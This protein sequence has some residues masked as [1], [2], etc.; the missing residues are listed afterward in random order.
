MVKRGSKVLR[1][2][3]KIDKEIQSIKKAE[4]K[5][6]VEEKKIEKEEEKIEKAI[7][8]L[9]RLTFKRQHFLELIRGTA[10]AF[11][12]VGLGLNLLNLKN[13]AT[14]LPWYN[15][16][17]ILIFILTISS[18]LIYKNEKDYVKTEGKK[19]VFKRLVFLY[20]IALVVE[21]LALELFGGI[22]DTNEIL[23]KMM[24]IGSYSAMAGAVSFSIV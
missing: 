20:I 6:I 22:P 11:L 18:L 7:F 1:K 8:K 13:L 5:T 14:N 9:G 19:I 21:F 17:G 10:G 12:G 24:I 23:I 2:L 3:D 15:V 16:I 4:S